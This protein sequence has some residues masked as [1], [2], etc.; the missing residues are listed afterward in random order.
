MLLLTFL[1]IV[2]KNVHTYF[3]LLRPRAHVNTEINFCLLSLLVFFSVHSDHLIIMFLSET[4]WHSL[5]SFTHVDLV[6]K[7]SMRVFLF[8]GTEQMIIFADFFC[9]IEFR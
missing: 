4:I 8:I 1:P 7:N 6:K 2:T 3:T 5:V 9:V